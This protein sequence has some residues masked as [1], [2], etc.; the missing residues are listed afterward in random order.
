MKKDP[1][2]IVVNGGQ[3]AFEIMPEQAQSLDLI[4]NGEANV[5][6][7]RNNQAYRVEI[8]SADAAGRNYVLRVNGSVFTVDIADYYDRLVQQLGLAVGGSLKINS[9]KAPMPGL[10]ISI[11]VT[12]GQTVQ[13][14]DPLV[15]LEAMKMENVI[16]AAGDGVVK[17]VHAQ[18][19]HPVDKGHMLLEFE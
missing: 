15:I 2:K 16:K 3:Y 14:G 18:K 5:H 1:F 13:K 19:G 7:L 17:N 9:V 12:P 10:V 8:V 11:L 6:L 4:P